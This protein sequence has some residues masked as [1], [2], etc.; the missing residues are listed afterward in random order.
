[1]SLVRIYTTSSTSPIVSLYGG[2]GDHETILRY[3]DGW[4][5][6]PDAKVNL[7]ERASGDGAHDV[8]AED[9]I[10]GTRTIVVDYRILT[11]SR[12][13]LLA[14]ESS[15]LSLA[16]QQVR[17][18][19]TDDDSDLFASGYVDSVVKD[20]SQQNLAKQTETGTL[21]IVCPR[22]ER[23]AW[24][25]LQSQL[26][27]VSAV[28]GGLLYSTV[29][30]LVSAWTGTLDASTSTLSQGGAV[31]ATNLFPYPK[32]TSLVPFAESL[33]CAASFPSSGGMLIQQTSDVS[34]VAGA[35]AFVKMALPP[36]AA[37]T[38]HVLATMSPSASVEPPSYGGRMMICVT[39]S[40]MVVFAGDNTVGQGSRS[41]TFTADGSTSYYLALFAGDGSG[42][43]SMSVLW[44]RIIIIS[45]SDWQA[46][47]ALG[48][49]WFDGDTYPVPTGK[50]L[51][52]PLNY[53]TGGIT[54]N[55]ALLINQ[56]SSKASRFSR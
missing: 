55:V 14:H 33:R 26:F 19:V 23:L 2:A 20:K 24:S 42:D 15:L 13:R 18:R 49:T 12:T 7:T 54:S 1:M 25:P 37:G 45:D 41:F 50:G 51:S 34:T 11:D 28:Q 35:G 5:S 10:Y 40:Q 6:T 52:Y 4:Y 21:T 44:Q 16:H 27:P 48:V 31:V 3:L 47:Q 38:Y 56:G 22:P 30:E 53:G 29:P 46:L 39:N 36:L 43:T 32:P 17:F 8:S 9:I